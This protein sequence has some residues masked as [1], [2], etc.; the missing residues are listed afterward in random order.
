MPMDALSTAIGLAYIFAAVLFILGLRY[1][2]SPATA[3]RGNLLAAIAMLIA[4]IVTLLDRQIVGFTWILIA[5]IIGTVIGSFSARLVKMTAMPQMVGIFNGLGGGASALVALAEF[6]RLSILSAELP[7]DFSITTLLSVFIGGLTF[8][9]SMIAFGK[10]QGLVSGSP[11]TFPLQKVVNA[12]LMVAVVVL[13][14]LIAGFD[15]SNILF[16]IVTLLALTLGVMLVIPIGGADMP[17]VISLLNS[18]SGL[19]ACAAGFVVQNHILII[20]GALVGAAGL[21]LTQIMCKAMNRPLSNVLFGAFGTGDQAAGAVDAGGDK[22]VKAVDGEEAAMILGYAQSV[23]VVP[24]FGMA[25]AQAQHAVRELSELLQKR[26]IEVKFA[27]HPVAGRMPGHMNVLLAEANVP[28]TLLFDMD[29]INPEF[30][31]ID[32]VLVIGAN[33]VINPAARNDTTSPIYGMPILDVDKARHVMIIKRSLN[34]GFAGIDNPLFYDPKTLM[35]FGSAK[36]K[37]QEL[38]AE[39][40]KL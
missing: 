37:V 17:V 14:V 34:V 19:A 2:G 29:D 30:P 11:I 8:T 32:V 5:I 27:I 35:Y 24:G 1:L 13:G 15:P 39:I 26:G 21:I 12:L 9:G 10:L 20:A 7:L 36:E 6:W 4:I 22:S 25:A 16:L 18:F 33:D 40:K 28:Y 23:V 3:R 38:V 31:H